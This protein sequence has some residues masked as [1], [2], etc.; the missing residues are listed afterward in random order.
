MRKP[1]RG[2]VPGTLVSPE[3]SVL[4]VLLLKNVHLMLEGEETYHVL[5]GRGP[6]FFSS[7]ATTPFP[8]FVHPGTQANKFETTF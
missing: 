6:L 5:L 2:P 7:T 3:V 4:G 8:A 1:N